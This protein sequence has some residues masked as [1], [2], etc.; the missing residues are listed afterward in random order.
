MLKSF[1]LAS[2]EYCHVLICA[3]MY[4]Y[5]SLII[6]T[7]KCHIWIEIFLSHHS[8]ILFQQINNIKETIKACWKEVDRQC[9]GYKGSTKHINHSSG[10]KIARVFVSS[11]FTDFHDEREIL[12]KKVIMILNKWPKLEGTD[13]M[14]ANYH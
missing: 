6:H 13:E 5:N 4:I 14:H 11:T 7:D 3:P 1:S 10:W 9:Q 12:I 8:F 2:L